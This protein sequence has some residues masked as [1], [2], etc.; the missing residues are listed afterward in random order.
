MLIGFHAGG[1]KVLPLL[2]LHIL[3]LNIVTDSLP[4]MALGADPID[5]Y[6]MQKKPRHKGAKIIDRQ[7]IANIGFVGLLIAAATLSLFAW[8]LVHYGLKTA[9]TMALTLLVLLETARAQMVRRQFNLSLFSNPWLVAAL[10]FTLLLQTIA[11]Y[12]TPVLL[13]FGVVISNPLKL[14]PL[15]LKI[16]VIMLAATAIVTAISIGFSKTLDRWVP[17]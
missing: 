11:V 17:D 4:A 12:L 10:A 13:A 3:W 15:P 14:S 2:A 7:M 5:Q 16:W 8:G 6:A 9:Q 1:Q